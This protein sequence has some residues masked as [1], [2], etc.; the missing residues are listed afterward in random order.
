[1][2]GRPSRDEA[3]QPLDPSGYALRALRHCYALR[4]LQ[5]C[6]ALRALQHCYAL[7]A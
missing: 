6:Y 3:L 7:R 2:Q 4:A 1:M 5:H